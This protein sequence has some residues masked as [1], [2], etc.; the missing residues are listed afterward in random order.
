MNSFFDSK[1]VTIQTAFD[2]TARNFLTIN[3][4]AFDV[5]VERGHD[6]DDW[7]SLP[8]SPFWLLARAFI[9]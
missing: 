9:G 1:V 4:P 8:S 2:S 5:C 3:C 7:Y 6:W